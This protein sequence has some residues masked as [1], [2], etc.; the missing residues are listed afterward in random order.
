VLLKANDPNG[1]G[2]S[3]ESAP[4]DALVGRSR[5]RGEK[6][7]FHAVIQRGHG[8]NPF[9]EPIKKKRGPTKRIK[10]Q[11]MLAMAGGL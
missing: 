7:G 10:A 5:Y 8:A 1:A 2:E 3:A 9:I 6:P 4:L 11:N